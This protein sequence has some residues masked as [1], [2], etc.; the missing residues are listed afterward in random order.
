MSTPPVLL[1]IGRPFAG[2][3]ANSSTELDPI[4]LIPALELKS[5]AIDD[6]VLTGLNKSVN[7]LNMLI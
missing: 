2:F 5:S 6:E 4:E 3:I 7:K 1:T